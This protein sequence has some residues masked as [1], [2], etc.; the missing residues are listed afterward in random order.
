MTNNKNIKKKM[1][2]CATIKISQLIQ[3]YSINFNITKINL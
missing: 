1:I 3:L 2:V